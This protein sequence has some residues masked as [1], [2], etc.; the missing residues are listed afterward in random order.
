MPTD[1]PWGYSE[2]DRSAPR[3]YATGLD[4]AEWRH[5]IGTPHGDIIV[6]GIGLGAMNLA[7]PNGDVSGHRDA[8][9]RMIMQAPAMRLALRMIALGIARIERTGTLEEFCFNGLRYSM[10]GD[11]NGLLHVIGW[12][13][14][15]AAVTKAGGA[16]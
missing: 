8:T 14:A 2:S 10:N 5:S 9:I 12:N 15:R 13:K 11:W 1:G 3:L 4:H 7:G 6:S 16:A